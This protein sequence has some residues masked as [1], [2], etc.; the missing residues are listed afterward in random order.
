MLEDFSFKFIGNI[1][2][3]NEL[4]EI[5]CSLTEY[6]WNK[7]KERKNIQGVAGGF[8]D[9]IPLIFDINR[10]MTSKIIHEKYE[11]FEKYITEIEQVAQD[12]FGP[13]T[14]KQAM[15]AR[16]KSG[17]VIKKHKDKSL[18][19][20]S[21]HRIHLPVITNPDCIFTIE[22]ESKHLK[23]GD[24]WAMDNAGKYHSVVNNGITDR[25]HLIVDV[26]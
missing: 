3:F 15:L 13:V 26:I 2:N 23:M 16:L 25:V 24:V 6:D 4:F 14:V 5:S 18:I 8:T 9:T 7:Y 17:S 21:T 12:V 20:V 22:G 19:T 10:D 1:K 11:M